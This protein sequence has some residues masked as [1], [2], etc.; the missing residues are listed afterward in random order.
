MKGIC[1][2]GSLER[3]A[4]QPLRCVCSDMSN[5]LTPPYHSSLT[6]TSSQPSRRRVLTS[7]DAEVDGPAVLSM[8]DLRLAQCYQFVE[9]VRPDQPSNA[10]SCLPECLSI[11]WSRK[12]GVRNTFLFTNRPNTLRAYRSVWLGRDK[13]SPDNRRVALKVVHRST[14]S[15]TSGVRVRSL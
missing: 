2:W 1:G 8:S 3:E 12:L 13:T 11:D 9:E 6:M 4:S 15:K 7:R 10:S 5:R 14:R